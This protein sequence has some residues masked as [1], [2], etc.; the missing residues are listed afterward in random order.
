[1]DCIIP[2]RPPENADET[3][4]APP[5]D[6]EPTEAEEPMPVGPVEDESGSGGKEVIG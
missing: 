1:M 2:G 4:A 5:P 3:W 6:G